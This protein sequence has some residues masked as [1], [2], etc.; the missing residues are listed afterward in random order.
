MKTL[1]QQ[2]CLGMLSL[3]VLTLSPPCLFSFSFPFLCDGIQGLSSPGD[4]VPLCAHRPGDVFAGV[5]SGQGARPCDL[6]VGPLAAV[7][8]D[9]RLRSGQTHLPLPYLVGPHR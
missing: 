8:T 2:P 4:W 6:L 1:Q 9:V 3:W 5:A 7:Q